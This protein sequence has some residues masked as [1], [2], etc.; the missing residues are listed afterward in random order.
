MANQYVYITGCTLMAHTPKALLIHIS[1]WD[2][3]PV[4]IPRSVVG[5][6]SDTFADA[7]DEGDLSIAEWFAIKEDLPF[8]DS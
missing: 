4:W 6:E 2:D 3:A 5:R 7:G 1:G 8:D